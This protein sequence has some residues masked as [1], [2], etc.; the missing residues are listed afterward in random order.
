VKD[1][2]KALSYG[3]TRTRR[4]GG[5]RKL[6]NEEFQNLYSSPSINRMIK[7]RRVRWARHVAKIGAK[8]NVYKILLGKLHG[9]RPLGRQRRRWVSNIKIDLKRDRT[10]WCGLDSSGSG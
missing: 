4:S 7:S 10:D 8:I 1:L 3:V 6:H 9:K 5:W 2:A